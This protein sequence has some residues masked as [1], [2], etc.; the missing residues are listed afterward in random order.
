[1]L[2]ASSAVYMCTA[3][4]LSGVALEK[5]S[6]IQYQITILMFMIVLC[7]TLAV[8]IVLIMAIGNRTSVTAI[9][10]QLLISEK[11]FESVL[12]PFWIYLLA[13]L[14]HMV[15]AGMMCILSINKRYVAY[16]DEKKSFYAEV[17]RHLEEPPVEVLP[18]KST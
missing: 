18:P 15:A 4:Q 3:L 9:A 11:K 10:P 16:L 14:F 5:A 1:M 2:H 13:I 12:G 7:D 17:K 6:I 8:C